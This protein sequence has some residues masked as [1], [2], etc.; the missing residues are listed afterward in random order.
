MSRNTLVYFRLNGKTKNYP[1][2]T[3]KSAGSPSLLHD[4]APDKED[5]HAL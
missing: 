5:P 4:V 3:R 2:P 1:R